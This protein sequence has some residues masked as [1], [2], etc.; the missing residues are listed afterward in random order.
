MLCVVIIIP[1]SPRVSVQTRTAG[2]LAEEYLFMDQ[3][4]SGSVGLKGSGSRTQRGVAFRNLLTAGF[5]AVFWV[6]LW[7][8][9]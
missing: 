4:L 3:N 1:S 2:P 5:F 6:S 9:A 7:L 8:P